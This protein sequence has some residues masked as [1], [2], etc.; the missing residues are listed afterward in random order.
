MSRS[1]RLLTT[2]SSIL[3]RSGSCA[4]S[5]MTFS[6]GR[7][8]RWGRPPKQAGT[9]TQALPPYRVSNTWILPT[10]RLG[11]AALPRASWRYRH[12]RAAGRGVLLRLRMY[13][14]LLRNPP[15]VGG[16]RGSVRHFRACWRRARPKRERHGQGPRR[17]GGDGQLLHLLEGSYSLRFGQSRSLPG[18]PLAHLSASGGGHSAH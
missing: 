2:P 8:W 9:T 15:V 5:C 18:P 7:L 4:G 10:P 14:V 11:G 17:F 12:G 16:A 6:T 13:H 1:R 3:R